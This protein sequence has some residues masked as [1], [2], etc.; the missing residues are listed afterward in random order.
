MSARDAAIAAS[1]PA[2]ACDR[3][4]ETARAL[5]ESDIAEGLASAT[6]DDRRDA[7]C[8]AMEER[9]DVFTRAT[10]RLAWEA[11]TE[12]IAAIDAGMVQ[13]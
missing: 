4:E 10:S 2:F 12:R 6:F 1:V 11:Y 3:I 9:G 7:L 8:D 5:A 13:S